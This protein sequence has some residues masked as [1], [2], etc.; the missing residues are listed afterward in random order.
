MLNKKILIPLILLTSAVF[1]IGYGIFTNYKPITSLFSPSKFDTTITDQPPSFSG[2]ASQMFNERGFYKS[3]SFSFDDN[4][5]ISDFNGNLM[6]EIPLYKFKGNGDINLDLK[7]VYNGSVNHQ[8]IL[9]PKNHFINNT[10]STRYN[11][12]SPEW[13]LSLNGICIQTL[14]FES[15]LLTDPG[16]SGDLNGNQIKKLI[17]GFHIDDRLRAVETGGRDRIFILMGDGSSLTLVNKNDN[18]SGGDQYTGTYYVDSKESHSLQGH[19]MLRYRPK[20][21]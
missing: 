4:E 9:A 19:W 16:V 2:D 18:Q 7:L 12:S 13:M 3:N 6:Y 8:I 10:N 5:I 15:Y 21:E 14:N 11:V 20:Q 17:P 1:A